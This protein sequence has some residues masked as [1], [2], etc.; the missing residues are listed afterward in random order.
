MHLC[1]FPTRVLRDLIQLLPNAM[2]PGVAGVYGAV[3]SYIAGAD[4]HR[5]APHRPRAAIVSNPER[6]RRGL[7]LSCNNT[8]FDYPLPVT[9]WS[10]SASMARRSHRKLPLDYD[11]ICDC[12]DEQRCEVCN[13]SC[14]EPD[15]WKNHDEIQ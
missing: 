4:R 9:T 14:T 1:L 7:E 12:L 8:G 3:A 10:T 15:C 6:S 2:Q 13:C 11:D 5:Y